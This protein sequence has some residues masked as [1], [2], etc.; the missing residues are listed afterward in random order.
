MFNQMQDTAEAETH[1]TLLAALLDRL[2]RRHNRAADALVH[3]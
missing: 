3:S 1:R 2:L